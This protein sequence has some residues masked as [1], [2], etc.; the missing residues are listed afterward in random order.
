VFT[1]SDVADLAIASPLA[2]CTF[3]A[4]LIDEAVAS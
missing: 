3:N 2:W 1:G 4:D